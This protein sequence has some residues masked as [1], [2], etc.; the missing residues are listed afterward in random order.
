M[1]KA[2]DDTAN[3]QLI[4]IGNASKLDAKRVGSS[5]MH[6]FTAQ[7]QSILLIN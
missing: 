4:R 5:V 7:R 6:D 3:C 1:I 2:P